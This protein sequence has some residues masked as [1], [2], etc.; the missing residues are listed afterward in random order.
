MVG[1]TASGKSD[2]ALD[3]VGETFEIVSADSVQV[4]RYMDI[5]SCKPEKK[6]L[7]RINH[8]LIDIVDPDYQFTAGEFCNR[9]LS[10]CKEIDSKNKIPLIAGGTGL[11]VS[12]FFG[13]I[14]EIPELDSDIKSILSKEAETR[15]L[16]VL[17]DELVRVDPEYALKIHRNDRQRII[18][19]LEVFRGTGR[20]F[21]DFHKKEKVYSG[22]DSFIIGLYL[23]RDELNRKIENRVDEMIR[24]GLVEEVE[25]LRSMGYSPGLN[26]MKSIG[27]SEINEYIDNKFS[28]NEAIEKIKTN[29]K[30]Y[31][32]KQ[33]T[34][35]K[36]M[37]E[38]L[39]FDN[40][41][42]ERIKENIKNWLK[43]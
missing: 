12:S 3:I 10:A 32:K 29:T 4:Y 27:Y 17:F 13:G 34:W 16:D 30:K 1:P 15:G 21:S 35:F 31:A 33:M 7:E 37:K 9:A 11:Y 41:E 26:S 23:E 2:L 43:Q 14:S 19:G 36:R 22:D 38:V 18:R 39:W 25:K 28:L 24:R 42:K 5:G 8:Y 6:D 20:P 40:K